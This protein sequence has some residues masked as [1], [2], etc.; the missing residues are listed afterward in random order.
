MPR[1]VWTGAISFGLVTIPI[2]VV[3]ASENRSIS[4]RQIHI[5]DAGRIR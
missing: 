4:F 1:P 5:E 3:S 2:K